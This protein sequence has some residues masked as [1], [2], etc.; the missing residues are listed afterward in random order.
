[1][2]L[3]DAL[4]SCDPPHRYSVGVSPEIFGKEVAKCWLDENPS[5][6]ATCVIVV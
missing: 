6:D 1:M 3:D 2:V 4:S 5:S